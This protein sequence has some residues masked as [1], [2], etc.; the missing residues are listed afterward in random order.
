MSEKLERNSAKR[1]PTNVQFQSVLP[2]ISKRNSLTLCLP[3]ANFSR[4][5]TFLHAIVPATCTRALRVLLTS[6]FF[7]LLYPSLFPLNTSRS[8]FAILSRSCQF[9]FV[10]LGV[11][12]R[13]P[14]I[15]LS[16]VNPR[17]TPRWTRVNT[18]ET[19][20]P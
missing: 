12:V 17:I 8:A 3:P 6:S 1:I 7:P 16:F 14:F 20:M 13:E 15:R 19:A 2:G 10:P 11:F 9:S 4:T 5:A 18:S